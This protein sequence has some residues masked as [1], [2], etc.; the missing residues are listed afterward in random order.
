MEDHVFTFFA[1]GFNV[2]CS[3]YFILR[4]FA[5]GSLFYIYFAGIG[6]L[7]SGYMIFCNRLFL[8][9]FSKE[10]HPALLQTSSV[11][12]SAVVLFFY[13][14]MLNFLDLKNEKFTKTIL[15]LGCIYMA[16]GIFCKMLKLSYSWASDVSVHFFVNYFVVV[17][18]LV[19]FSLLFYVAR[20][21]KRHS[22][23]LLLGILVIIALGLCIH[24]NRFFGW[25]V[26]RYHLRQ[27][28]ILT[29]NVLFF[30][31]ILAKEKEDYQKIT[32]ELALAE[33]QRQK[34]ILDERDRI[35]RDIHDEIG[36]GVSAIKLHLELL[37]RKQRDQ[38]EVESDLQELLSV[39]DGVNQAMRR[40][41]QNL[42]TS[43]M[44]TGTFVSYISEYCEQ[45]LKKAQIRYVFMETLT[46]ELRVLPPAVTRHLSLCIK[47]ALN[48]IYKHSRAGEVSLTV[49]QDE[50][51]LVITLKDNGVGFS[52][53]GRT[54]SC[55]INNMKNRM[56]LIGGTFSIQSSEKG[57]EVLLRA[58][59]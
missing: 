27:A 37:S 34:D 10:W 50:T 35:A 44:M 21:R 40:M 48:N 57:T 49:L 5:K 12:L 53:S 39:S 55:G 25:D 46:D 38:K 2:S 30:L 20:N 26:S 28:E 24:G 18:A 14:F 23:Y 11:S 32:Q 56:E 58:A 29:G 33:I 1:I 15:R 54:D 43:S 7:H 59:V 6:I 45:F 8:N 4:Y 9:L 19:L 36:A 47:E 42:D 17:D 51:S 31:M 52:G 22:F 41:I 13:L 3:L 16:V